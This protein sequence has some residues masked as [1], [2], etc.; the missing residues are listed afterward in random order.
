MDNVIPAA[1]SVMARNFKKLGHFFD[2][3]EYHAI[4]AQ[5][6]RNIKKLMAKYGSA[7]SN[8]AMLLLD[9][10]LGTYEVAIT[11]PEADA[12]RKEFEKRYVP[13]KIILGGTK[14]SLPL[15]Q[16]KLSTQTRIFVCVDKTCQLPVNEV[17]EAFKQIKG[18]E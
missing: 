15:L 4:A 13:N 12:K 14:G 1:N 3:E 6:L 16:D 5:M 8:W 9:D 10:V 18:L 2:E 7:Y 17:T 11:G